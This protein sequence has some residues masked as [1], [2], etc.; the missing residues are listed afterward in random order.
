MKERVVT[1]LNFFVSITDP[2]IEYFVKIKIQTKG[3][4]MKNISYNHS[5]HWKK[6][7]S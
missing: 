2:N 3:I 7:M 1:K 5:I 6:Y 4:G